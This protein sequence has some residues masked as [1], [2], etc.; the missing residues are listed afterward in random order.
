M[1]KLRDLSRIVGKCLKISL[2]TRTTTL[3]WCHMII[4]SPLPCVFS[5]PR[6]LFP[7]NWADRLAASAW[8]AATNLEASTSNIHALI[9]IYLSSCLPACL[10][11]WLSVTL[12][13]CLCVRACFVKHTHASTK[14]F[15][16][17]AGSEGIRFNSIQ[18]DSTHWIP[19]ST[20]AWLHIGCI[21]IYWFAD[22]SKSRVAVSSHPA[23]PHMCQPSLAIMACWEKWLQKTNSKWLQYDTLAMALRVP[24]AK[25]LACLIEISQNLVPPLT[26][27]LGKAPPTHHSSPHAAHAAIAHWRAT[28]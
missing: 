20:I 18:L 3:I 13:V 19:L 11:G 12:S 15:K 9:S 1:R 6:C 7:F 28:R 14:N 16:G 10:P 22:V 27:T 21:S 25:A 4:Y 5:M 24:L 23:P 26:P 8:V 2:K 17:F